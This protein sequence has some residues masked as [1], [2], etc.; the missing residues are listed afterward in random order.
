M[1]KVNVDVEQ[2]KEI[3]SQ[4]IEERLKEIESHV[5]F[6]NSEQ[7]EEYVNMS[8]NSITAH[9][10]SDEEFPK[11]RLGRRWLFPRKKVKLYM[12]KYYEE[13]RDD[14]GDISKFKR[15]I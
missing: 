12:E 8:W 4:K 9:L 14:G 13:V 6:L 7:L 3:Y 1:I 10:M 5:F 2:L 11:I 15:K